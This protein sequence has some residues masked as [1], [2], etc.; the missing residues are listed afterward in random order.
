MS[1]VIMYLKL[2]QRSLRFLYSVRLMYIFLE[3][4]VVTG[5]E[6]KAEDLCGY[7]SVGLSVSVVVCRRVFLSACVSVGCRCV[8]VAVTRSVWLCLYVCLLV[9]VCLSV[10]VGVSM[11]L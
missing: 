5:L 6:W 1:L 2:G 7:V 10:S 11:C 3:V 4:N 8:R 9:S